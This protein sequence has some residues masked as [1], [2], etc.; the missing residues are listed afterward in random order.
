MTEYI[1][2]YRNEPTTITN[3]QLERETI[4]LTICYYRNPLKYFTLECK[5]FSIIVGSYD[6]HKYFAFAII[7][8]AILVGHPLPP[9]CYI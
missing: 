6:N 2:D 5:V 7:V 4:A 3:D 1:S 9:T 8:F